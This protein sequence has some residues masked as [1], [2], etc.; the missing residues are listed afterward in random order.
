M[1]KAFMEMRWEFVMAPSGKYFI[2]SDNPVVYDTYFGLKRSPLFFPID[3]RTALIATW[4]GERDLVYIDGS[5]EQLL[6]IN[7]IILAKAT[8]EIYS[9]TADQWIHQALENG[10]VISA[11]V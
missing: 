11:N 6:K 1:H 10:V 8:K 9:H 5:I 7:G 3:Q 2:T 4:H